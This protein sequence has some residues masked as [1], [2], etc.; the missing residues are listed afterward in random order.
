MPGNG[1]TQ[2][3]KTR[4]SDKTVNLQTPPSGRWRV[5]ENIGLSKNFYLLKI[6]KDKS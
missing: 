6:V 1:A 3:L 4:F 5:E 2:H